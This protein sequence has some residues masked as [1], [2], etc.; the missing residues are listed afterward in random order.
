MMKEKIIYVDVFE[1]VIF[2]LNSK[3]PLFRI[4]R[5]GLWVHFAKMAHILFCFAIVCYAGCR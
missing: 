5:K 4:G 3:E 2:D 1:A